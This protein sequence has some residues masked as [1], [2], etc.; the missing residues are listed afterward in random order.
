MSDECFLALP[1]HY[2]GYCLS[3]AFHESGPEL[4]N[5]VYSDLVQPYQ[6]FI[7]SLTLQLGID[8]QDVLS[9]TSFLQLMPEYQLHTGHCSV[10]LP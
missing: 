8:A 3:T 9:S 4:H 7:I 5:L 10:V 1:P 6:L 2:S